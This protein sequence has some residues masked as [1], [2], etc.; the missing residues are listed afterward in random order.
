LDGQSAQALA[1]DVLTKWVQI[2]I[3]G[4]PNKTGW[5]SIQTRFVAVSGD[6]VKL[7]EVM[8]TDWPVQASLRNCTY[9]YMAAEPGGIVIQAVYNFPDNEVQINPG[10]YTIH[11]IEV[12]GSPEVMQVEIKEGSEIDIRDD[13][14]GDHKKCVAP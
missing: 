11:D 1:R 9:H 5:I 4:H 7:P 3:S 8:P 13:G 6:V 2:P 10:V 12:D 14:D